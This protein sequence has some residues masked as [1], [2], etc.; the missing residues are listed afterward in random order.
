VAPVKGRTRDTLH[1]RHS[2]PAAHPPARPAFICPSGIRSPAP[3][4]RE[5]VHHRETESRTRKH[6]FVR[7]ADDSL[8]K[9][10]GSFSSKRKSA[11][12]YRLRLIRNIP[13]QQNVSGRKIAILI[14]RAVSND[15]DDIRPHIAFALAALRSI[16]S[17]QIVQVGACS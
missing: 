10:M 15:S 2:I 11:S 6:R 4:P 14:V 3:A 1:V 13:H 5:C 17:G 8:A 12:T 16:K 7:Y 9:K